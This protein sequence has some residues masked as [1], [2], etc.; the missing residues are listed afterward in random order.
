MREDFI[1][2]EIFSVI[3]LLVTLFVFHPRGLISA[4]PKGY[5]PPSPGVILFGGQYA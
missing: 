3:K 5:T 1:V 2:K 4:S